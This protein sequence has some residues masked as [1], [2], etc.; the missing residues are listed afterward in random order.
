M[1]RRS[2]TWFIARDGSHVIHQAQD[3]PDASIEERFAGI[4]AR[5]DGAELAFMAV[6]CDG[7]GLMVN[8]EEPKLPEGWITCEL[9]ELCPDC[10]ANVGTI[11]A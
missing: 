1:T 3:L 6:R 7:C 11:D 2:E 9:G 4:R 10:C 8:V 5:G